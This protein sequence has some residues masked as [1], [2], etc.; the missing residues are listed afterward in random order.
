MRS[1]DPSSLFWSYSPRVAGAIGYPSEIG[2]GEG[3]PSRSLCPKDDHG[4]RRND[5]GTDS[6]CLRGGLHQNLH[7]GTLKGFE[8]VLKGCYLLLQR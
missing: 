1:A 2:S 6:E 7:L 5:S 8:A 4:R 3:K